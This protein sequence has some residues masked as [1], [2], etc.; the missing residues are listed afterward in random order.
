LDG[1]VRLGET[2]YTLN[3]ANTKSV[4]R[5]RCPNEQCVEGDFDLSA[6]L[7]NA[8]FARKEAAE[9]ELICQSW[10]NRTTIDRVSCHHTLCYKL[11]LGH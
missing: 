10:R 6:N 5:L 3:L 7:A 11:V 9:G 1:R 4:F 2:E 8:I